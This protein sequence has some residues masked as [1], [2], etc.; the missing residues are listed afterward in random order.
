MRPGGRTIGRSADRPGRTNTVDRTANRRRTWTTG[1]GRPGR[2]PSQPG[3]LPPSSRVAAQEPLRLG[4]GRVQRRPRLKAPTGGLSA[5]GRAALGEIAEKR[6]NHRFT[7]GEGRLRSLPE[8]ARR[9]ARGSRW[10]N[11]MVAASPRTAAHG[12]QIEQP[13]A[14]FT[15]PGTWSTPWY[16]PFS[17]TGWRGGGLAAAATPQFGPRHP[18]LRPVVLESSSRCHFLPTPNRGRRGGPN[19]SV[20]RDGRERVGACVSS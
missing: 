7:L 19:L 20:R 14:V 9:T 16:H 2:R 13:R 11:I 10:H 18:V 6:K 17:P 15:H 1:P 8:V 12:T 5:R 3:Q 4:P